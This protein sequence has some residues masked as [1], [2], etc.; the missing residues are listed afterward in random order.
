MTKIGS[1][2]EANC[3]KTPRNGEDGERRNR[4][5]LWQMSFVLTTIVG[6]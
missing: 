6:F 5:D 2:L 1:R 3:K 4:R